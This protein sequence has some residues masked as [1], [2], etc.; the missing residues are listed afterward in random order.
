MG[1]AGAAGV[2]AGTHPDGSV[3]GAEL[4]VDQL[5]S[6]S[7]CCGLDLIFGLNALLR[8]PRN[9]WNSSNAA[10]L[11]RYCEARR[12]RMSWELGNGT[13]PVSKRPAEVE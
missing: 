2:P 13:H 9:S 10:A 4:T 3:C 5:Q 7:S 11:L 1:S 12:Y 6:F 8:T